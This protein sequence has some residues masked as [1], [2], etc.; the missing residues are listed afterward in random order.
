[1]R[2]SK[3]LEYLNTRDEYLQNAFK[4]AREGKLRKASEFLWGAVAIQIK[5]VALVRK[6]LTLGTHR[7]LREFMRQLTR[8]LNDPEL[9]KSFLLVEKLHA[10]FYDEIIDPEDF[11][12]YMHEA[13]KLIEKLEQLCK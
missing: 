11:E 2:N 13:L 12:I 5:L 7:D 6:N 3:L 4:F 10:N 9:Y 8:E 1:M